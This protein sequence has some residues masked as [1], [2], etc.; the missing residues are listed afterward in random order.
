MAFELFLGCSTTLA[1]SVYDSLTR[2]ETRRLLNATVSA[3]SERTAHELLSLVCDAVITIDGSLCL[4]A[5]S[6]AL[7]ALLFN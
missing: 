3:R 2:S 6:P 1:S 7:D 4:E 5:P